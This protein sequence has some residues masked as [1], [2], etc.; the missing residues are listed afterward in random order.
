MKLIPV[1]LVFLTLA[2]SVRADAPDTDAQAALLLAT[3][4]RVATVEK[5]LGEVKSRLAALEAKPAVPQAAPA[6][7]LPAAPTLNAAG[8]PTAVAPAGMAWRKDG[9]LDGPAPWLLVPAATTPAFA[10]P[11]RDAIFQ[12]AAPSGCP[13]GQCPTPARS[14]R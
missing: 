14:R 5:E 13:N 9:T 7:A 8:V 10:T 2:G 1:L 12:F 11:V 3:A 4:R 6:A